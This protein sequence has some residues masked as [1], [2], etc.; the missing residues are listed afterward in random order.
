MILYGCLQEQKP[1]I[2]NAFLLQRWTV[3]P[4]CTVKRCWRIIL[5]SGR[6]P[7]PRE[8]TKAIAK[9]P[10]S[11]QFL[12]CC[13]DLRSTLISG[14]LQQNIFVTLSATLAILILE[15]FSISFLFN[16][17]SITRI[18]TPIPHIPTLIPRV[19]P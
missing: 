4:C 10:Q 11:T 12:C 7:N 19:P 2:T 6:S 17:Y 14:F 9:T 18:L 1:S 3:L 8:V 16:F 13:T 15:F 5:L